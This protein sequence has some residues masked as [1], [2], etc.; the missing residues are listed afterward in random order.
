[1][2][3]RCALR[4]PRHLLRAGGCGDLPYVNVAAVQFQGH[5]EALSTQAGWVTCARDAAVC[6]AVWRD[7]GSPSAL[8]T[9]RHLCQTL[10]FSAGVDIARVA[11]G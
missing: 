4:D 1:M 6:L 8:S 11:S 7:G 3:S 10:T 9:H 2:V 5:P